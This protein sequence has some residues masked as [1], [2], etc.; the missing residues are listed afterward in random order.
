MLERYRGEIILL[1]VTIS[2]AIGWF[3]SKYAIDA[4]PS[5]G[6]IGLRFFLAALVFLPFAYPHLRRLSHRQVLNALLIGGVFAVFLGVWILAI[7]NNTNFGEGAFLTSLSMLIAPLL[8]W[9]L[10]KQKPQSRFW[11]SLPIAISGLYFL[12]LGD[13]GFNLSSE[14]SLYL[15]TSLLAA[16]YFVL[17]HHYVR[18]I[19]VLPLTTIQLA[20]VGILCGLY[21]IF[22]ETWPEDIPNETWGWLAASVLIAT[23]FRFLLQTL[24]QKY[25]SV[26]NAALIMLL[27]PVWTLFLSMMIFHEPIT[28]HKALG[29]GLIFLALM[30]YRLPKE[31]L[32]QFLRRKK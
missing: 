31:K 24:G 25:S 27:E 4:L 12:A 6:F 5:V 20:M 10:F 9:L 30:F 22:M 13:N 23:N 16:T 7:T 26:G 14:N 18:H 2:A 28:S 17:N 1:F 8:A 19:P 15:L 11:L 32:K 29:C 21:S 3:F